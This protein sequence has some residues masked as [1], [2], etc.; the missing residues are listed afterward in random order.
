MVS[1][2]GDPV[3]AGKG[4]GDEFELK[5]FLWPSPTILRSAVETMR[6]DYMVRQNKINEFI[7]AMLQKSPGLSQPGHSL[8][9]SLHPLPYAAAA[10]AACAKELLSYLDREDLSATLPPVPSDTVEM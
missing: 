5:G 8:R 4:Y 6:S 9:T 3:R 7:S 2:E 1:M 10:A